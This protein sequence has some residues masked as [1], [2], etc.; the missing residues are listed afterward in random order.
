MATAENKDQYVAD[1][2]ALAILASSRLPQDS[3][4]GSGSGRHEEKI[5]D[6]SSSQ[7]PSNNREQSQQRP[8]KNER[9]W[10]RIIRN[11]SPSWFSVTMGTGIVSIL[12]FSIPYQARWLYYL[13]IIFFVLNILLFALALVASAVR[14]TVWPEIWTVMIRD[15]NNSL[16]LGTV[17]MGFATLVEMLTFVCVP[18]WGP[19]AATAAWALWMLDSVAAVGVTVFLIFSHIS[20]RA[21]TATL[22]SLYATQLLPIAATIVAAGTGAEVAATLD[23]PKQALGTVIAC[24][25][26]WGMATPLAFSVLVIYYQRLHLHKLPP[27]ETV[28]SCFLPLGPLGFGGYTIM[29]LGKVARDVFPATNSLAPAAG[30]VLYIQGWL[31]ALVMWGAGLVWLVFALSALWKSRPVPFNMGWWG[32]T[33]P[34]GVFAAS[35]IQIGVEMPSAFFRALGTAFGVA[36]IL[37]WIVV[38]AGTARGAWSGKLFHAPCLNQLRHEQREEREDGGAQE[39]VGKTV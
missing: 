4:S 14:Y 18:A 29:Y 9:G 37:L 39:E 13:S 25:V 30:D 10:R 8:H 6:E 17:P 27:R 28:V 36:V 1:T 16:F 38:A 11:F 15:P 12:F 23:D 22:A 34:L 21:H 31:V 19:R 5:L 35:T 33:F 7:S 2:P 26:L 3:G 24:F 20:S 32:F